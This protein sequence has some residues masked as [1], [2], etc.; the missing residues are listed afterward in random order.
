MEDVLEPKNLCIAYESP[1]A[2]SGKEIDLPDPPSN[3]RA[4]PVGGTNE[5]MAAIKGHKKPTSTVSKKAAKKTNAPK[6]KGKQPKSKALGPKTSAP[7]PAPTGKAKGIITSKPRENSNSY[8]KSD[9]PAKYGEKKTGYNPFKKAADWFK[10][11]S[12]NHTASREP[13]RAGYA[14]AV[15]SSKPPETVS[16]SVNV[17]RHHNSSFVSPLNSAVKTNAGSNQISQEDIE[18]LCPERLPTFW[19]KKQG[20]DLAKLEREQDQIQEKCEK[21]KADIKAGKRIEALPFFDFLKR[22]WISKPKPPIN[23]KST[24]NRKLKKGK[25]DA[26]AKTND[27]KSNEKSLVTT[28]NPANSKSTQAAKAAPVDSNGRKAANLEAENGTRLESPIAILIALLVAYCT[29]LMLT[30]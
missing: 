11:K 10:S 8:G 17:T 14:F 15:A 16:T 13:K 5:T 9:K 30:A 22:P 7:K 4:G 25:Q 6:G 28:T 2:L 18:E 24:S 23:P 20:G 27:G 21:L 29:N 12:K 19:L 1:K 26:S 3:N